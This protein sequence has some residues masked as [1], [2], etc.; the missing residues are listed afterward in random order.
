MGMRQGLNFGNLTLNW[1]AFALLMVA[2]AAAAQSV[3]FYTSPDHNSFVPVSVA[4]AA[5]LSLQS[6]VSG[7]PANQG[8][9]VLGGGAFQYSG[10]GSFGAFDLGAGKNTTV[11]SDP[12]L[13][14]VHVASDS[15]GTAVWYFST[16]QRKVFINAY[17]ASWSRLWSKDVTNPGPTFLG[18]PTLAQ[19]SVFYG[20]GNNAISASFATGQANWSAVLPALTFDTLTVSSGVV[21][22]STQQGLY[23]LSASSGG[24]LWSPPAQPPLD[25]SDFARLVVANGRYACRT[26]MN[27]SVSLLDLD[28]GA[29]LWTAAPSGPPLDTRHPPILGDAGILVP[30]VGGLKLLDYSG[31][32]VWMSPYAF[33]ARKLSVPAY[34]MLGNVVLAAGADGLYAV[35]LADGTILWK[36]LSSAEVNGLQYAGGRVYAGFRDNTL[37]IYTLAP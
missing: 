10:A 14:G 30:Q 37:Q 36:S 23:A 12:G 9:F 15:G 32:T 11:V 7:L 26:A 35:S 2:R 18:V 6:T 1:L 24:V 8:G 21:L 13:S 34:L 4:T 22:A 28:S 17:D 33:L 27:G 5:P 19:G 31:K 20:S 29:V 16:A 25:V 3:S